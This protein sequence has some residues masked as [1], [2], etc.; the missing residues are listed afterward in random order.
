MDERFLFGLL[1]GDAR[2]SGHNF[3]GLVHVWDRMN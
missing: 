2:V 3:D 1:D